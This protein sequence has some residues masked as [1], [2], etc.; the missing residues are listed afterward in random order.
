MPSEVLIEVNHLSRHFPGRTHH[1]VAVDDISFTLN[2]G[3]ILG[4]LGPNGA[5]KS[6]TMQMLT[7]NLAPTR[8]EI[9]IGGIDLMDNPLETKAQIGYLPDTPPL[10]KELT[11]N[12]YLR[13]CARLN[14]IPR[15]QLD[16]ALASAKHRCGL[17]DYGS[18]VISHLSKG[19]QQRVGIAQAIIHSPDIVI[20]DEPT[21]GLDP[22][23]MVE[24]RKLIKELGQ[25]HS[26]MLSSHI[27]PEIQAICNQVQIINQGKLVFN[28]PIELLNQQ[29]QTQALRIRCIEAVDISKIEQLVQVQDVEQHEDSIL[30]HCKAENI[31][32]EGSLLSAVSIAQ[33][34]IKLSLDN[35]WGLYE[36]FP[37]KRTLEDIFMALTHVDPTVSQEK[38]LHD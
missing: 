35:H 36:I 19:Y 13:Y 15:N 28:A 27:L 33:Q 18:R 24:I 32:P 22:I 11:V 21:V 6:T 14:K 2:R 20:L 34:V 23:Q 30:I 38:D 5:G 31:Q 26:V 1:T 10:Y 3:E 17:T 4:F 12:E 25:Q 7:G 8:G 37:E 9:K 29:M 16:T